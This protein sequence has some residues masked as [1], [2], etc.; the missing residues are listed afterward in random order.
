M[1]IQSKY[2]NTQVEALISELLAVLAKH[3]APTDLSLMVLG[4][5]VTHLLDKKVPGESRQKVAEQFAKAL[6]QSVK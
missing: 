4:N 1:A 2:T 6:T 5:C 3:Q